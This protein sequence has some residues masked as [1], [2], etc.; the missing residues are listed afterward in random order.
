MWS[1]QCNMRQPKQIECNIGKN[2]IGCRLLANCHRGMWLLCVNFHAIYHLR[3]IIIGTENLQTRSGKRFICWII[4]RSSLVKYLRFR[5]VLFWHIHKCH[6][7]NSTWF[8][9][10]DDGKKPAKQTTIVLKVGELYVF[11]T[12]S[13]T[14]KSSQ[15]TCAY[16][17]AIVYTVLLHIETFWFHFPV[18]ISTDSQMVCNM[19]SMKRINCT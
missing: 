10:F 17:F 6:T 8:F 9:Q 19:L 11:R 7:R 3:M 14:L 1:W 5:S 2:G 12:F 15:Y 16:N 13:F 18:T 4:Q